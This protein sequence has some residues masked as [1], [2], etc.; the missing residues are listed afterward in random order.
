MIRVE[1]FEEK[2][3]DLRG[4]RRYTLTLKEGLR[5]SV[6]T[7]CAL[8]YM[9]GQVTPSEPWDDVYRSDP[10]RFFDCYIENPGNDGTNA[11]KIVEVFLES[12]I[13]EDLYEGSAP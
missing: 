3:F 7:S 8:F 10:L 9:Q 2:G 1:S 13:R 12:I 4:H 6:S 11:G 5:F